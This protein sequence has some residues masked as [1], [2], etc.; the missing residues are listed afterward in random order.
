M[1]CFQKKIENNN[2]NQLFFSTISGSFEN[3]LIGV[4]SE[5]EEFNQNKQGYPV[6]KGIE[7][8]LEDNPIVAFFEF[9]KWIWW[10]GNQT[11]VIWN[12]YGSLQQF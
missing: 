8:K 11:Q 7:F 2:Q 3:G 9:N 10:L 4:F 6:L 12:I 1:F 5:A